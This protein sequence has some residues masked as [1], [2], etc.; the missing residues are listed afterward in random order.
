MRHDL[1]VTDVWEFDFPYHNQFKK[2]VIEH[3]EGPAGQNHLNQKSEKLSP[4]L[5]SYG[6]EEL[7]YDSEVSLTSFFELHMLRFFQKI[8]EFHNWEKGKWGNFEQWLNVNKKGSFNPPHVHSSANFSGCYYVKH[9][10]NSGHIHFLDPRPQ[11]RFASPD[12]APDVMHQIEG[13]HVFNPYCNSHPH[14]SSIFTY[15]IKEGK[16]IIF[17]SWLMHYVDPNANEDLRISI[18]FNCTYVQ[19]AFYE[20]SER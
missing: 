16:I 19:G 1:F 12:P 10:K 6:G 8:E 3:V 14:D 13:S 18:A 15:E 17:P 11:H 5:T 4:S 7:H 2:Q 20:N 9:P